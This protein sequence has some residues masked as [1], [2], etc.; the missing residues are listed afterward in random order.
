M[1]SF[2]CR[3]NCTGLSRGVGLKDKYSEVSTKFVFMVG[4]W[5]VFL[6]VAEEEFSFGMEE[7]FSVVAEEEFSFGR[8]EVFSVEEIC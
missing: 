4:S 6:V 3:R 5:E 1:Y 2:C 8:E 7:V